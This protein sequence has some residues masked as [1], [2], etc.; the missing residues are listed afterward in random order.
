MHPP[1]TGL[2]RAAAKTENTSSK[3]SARE[4][5]SGR[6]SHHKIGTESAGEQ[7]QAGAWRMTQVPGAKQES[8]ANST[9]ARLR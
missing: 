4:I 6:W 5:E 2:T 7:D 3:A 8:P 9:R 1:N